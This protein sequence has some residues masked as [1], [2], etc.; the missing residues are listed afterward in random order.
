MGK[1]II[2]L[3]L[4]ALVTSFGG[5]IV[6]AEDMTDEQSVDIMTRVQ[7]RAYRFSSRPPKNHKGMTLIRE[8]KVKNGYIVYYI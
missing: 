8:K 1:V 4:M 2:Y 3:G 6:G 7:V 5:V